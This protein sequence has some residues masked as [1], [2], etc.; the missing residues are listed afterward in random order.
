MKR[1]LRTVGVQKPDS[2]DGLEMFLTFKKVFDKQHDSKS[3]ED[4]TKFLTY[5][6]SAIEDIDEKTNKGVYFRIIYVCIN[7]FTYNFQ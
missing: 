5:V 7:L 4:F 3:K 1:I 6:K 2:T